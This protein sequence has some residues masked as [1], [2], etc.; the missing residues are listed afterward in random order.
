MLPTGL[1]TLYPK[2]VWLPFAWHGSCSMLDRR[3]GLAW[4]RDRK[5]LRMN[6]FKIHHY[7]TGR[8]WLLALAA[9]LMRPVGTL[10]VTE[11]TFKVL[12]IG[13]RTYTNVTVT[14]KARSYIFIVHADGM[15]SLKV[16]ELP[17]DVQQEL[18]YLN[19]PAPKAA[20]NTASAWVTK[21]IAKIDTP[22]VK[23][24]RNQLEQKW[25]GEPVARLSALGLMGPKL[26]WTALGIVALLWL[27][28]YL[29]Y[30][31]CCMLICRKAGHPP[32]VLV[33]LPFVKLF[34][35]FRA[36]GMS[37]WWLVAFLV[38]VLNLVP[39]ILWP[40]KITKVRGKSVWVAVLLLLPVSSLFAFL[41][42]TFSDGTAEA[43]DEGPEP[44]VMSLQT[45]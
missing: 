22:Q 34:P 32:G 37:C 15:A 39:L 38:P 29:F 9:L 42:L 17:T 44:K 20:T 43:D 25:R 45:A 21:G 6:A 31:Y 41:Y 28:V 33:W 35:M 14:T 19:A 5:S 18:G 23:D 2:P 4:F 12:R 26:N 40:L 8:L 30:S 11:D 16:S 13:A 36:A 7:A 3:F 1:V 10:G 27:S 24:L